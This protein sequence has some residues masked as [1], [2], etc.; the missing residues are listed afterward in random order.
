MLNRIITIG[1]M[2]A[3]AISCGS[4]KSSKEPEK[5]LVQT[6]APQQQQPKYEQPQAPIEQPVDVL[7][8]VVGLYQQKDNQNVY[9]RIDGSQNV[10]TTLELPIRTLDNTARM[11]PEFP[12]Q[13]RY[14]SAD[15]YYKT[16]GTFNRGQNSIENVEMKARQSDNGN[17]L[18]VT[19]VVNVRPSDVLNA[20]GSSSQPATPTTGT[21]QPNYNGQ[22]IPGYGTNYPTTGYGYPTTGYPNTGY[23]TTGTG[24]PTTGYPTTGYPTNGYPQGYPNNGNY[25]GYPYGTNG[26]TGFP[27][28]LGVYRAADEVDGELSEGDVNEAR[29]RNN[30]NSDCNR[31]VDIDMEDT[32]SGWNRGCGS[33]CTPAARRVPVPVPVP[34]PVMG[35]CGGATCGGGFGVGGIIG[36]MLGGMLPG[37]SGY[38]GGMYP[39]SGYPGTGVGYPGT[40]YPN[41]TGTQNPA[42]PGGNCE[43]PEQREFVYR[44]IRVG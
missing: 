41:G 20:D 37:M 40:G 28:G 13:L 11:I 1:L 9:L 12:Q 36:G 27:Y 18:D 10:E 32:N 4:K 29:R 34:V 33:C 31:A 38:P 17:I 35:G 43:Q 14:D 24:Y 22:P 25:N 30:N 39:G 26:Q 21:T 15:G 23:P 16:T 44:F 19:L 2:S 3:L 5:T 42:C 8:L 7:S 6:P